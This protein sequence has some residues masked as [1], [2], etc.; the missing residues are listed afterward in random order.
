MNEQEGIVRIVVHEERSLGLQSGQN[1]TTIN[2]T[3]VGKVVEVS[4]LVEVRH[5]R[6]GALSFCQHVSMLSTKSFCNYG[7]W[8]NDSFL[9]MG[10]FGEYVT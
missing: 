3:N 10:M 7:V 4:N 1:H 2:S 8:L 6:F 5:F 9:F